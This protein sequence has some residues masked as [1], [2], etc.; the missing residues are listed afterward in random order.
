MQAGARGPTRRPPRGRYWN[1]SVRYTVLKTCLIGEVSL[2]MSRNQ[3]GPR[4]INPPPPHR[5]LSLTQCGIGSSL[6][7]ADCSPAQ[8]KL[9]FLLS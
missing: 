7:K 1:M 4:A 3:K 5:Q 2:Q 9:L 6:H 8:T